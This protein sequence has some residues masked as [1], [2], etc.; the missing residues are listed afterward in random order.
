MTKFQPDFW[1]TIPKNLRTVFADDIF[2]HGN[3]G[4]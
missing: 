1:E 3:H 4:R 2:L